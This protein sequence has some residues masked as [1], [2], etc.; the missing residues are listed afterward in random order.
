MPKCVIYLHTISAW[1]EKNGPDK[2]RQAH[3]VTDIVFYQY[4]AMHIHF[5]VSSSVQIFGVSVLVQVTVNI[6]LDASFIIVQA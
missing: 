5:G 3:F 4:S 2:N 6:S 1:L